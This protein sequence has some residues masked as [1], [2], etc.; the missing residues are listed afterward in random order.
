MAD[1]LVLELSH[2]EISGS[3][4]VSGSPELFAAVH[5]LLR[6]LS[7]RHPPCALCSLTQFLR[8]ASSWC[9]ESD[10]R[11][12]LTL[13][14]HQ[15]SAEID[16]CA[17]RSRL[18]LVRVTRGVCREQPTSTFKLLAFGR[19]YRFLCFR[20]SETLRGV[21]SRGAASAYRTLRLGKDLGGVELT[22][23]EPVA[24]GLQSPRSPS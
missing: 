16:A 9:S 6:L 8:H 3:G 1:S 13:N 23:I 12:V 14:L 20:M 10:R 19:L 21:A 7:P 18:S 15:R 4:P 24:S 22:G 11:I 2:S 17:F 5:V